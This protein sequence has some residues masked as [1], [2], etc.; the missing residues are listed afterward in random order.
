MECGRCGKEVTFAPNRTLARCSCG[1]LHR[2]HKC[3]L[4]NDSGTRIIIRPYGPF[5]KPYKA[6]VRCDCRGMDPVAETPDFQRHAKGKAGSAVIPRRPQ[7][8]MMTYGECPAEWKYEREYELWRHKASLAERQ[9]THSDWIVLIQF[10][11]F[12]EQWALDKTGAGEI[13]KE[14]EKCSDQ[15]AASGVRG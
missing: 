6:A 12:F 4:C 7:R 13:S 3:L 9:L 15:R 5:C 8:P 2:W 11:Q 1:A 10:P 14:G